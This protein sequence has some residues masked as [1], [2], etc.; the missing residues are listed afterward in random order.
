MGSVMMEENVV[1]GAAEQR[2]GR[3]DES[4]RA[5]EQPSSNLNHL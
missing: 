5:S 1:S 2:E 4:T 3:T